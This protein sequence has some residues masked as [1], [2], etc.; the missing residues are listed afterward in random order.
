M[1]K[2][3]KQNRDYKLKSTRGPVRYG[4]RPSRQELDRLSMDWNRFQSHYGEMIHK[5]DE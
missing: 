4:R 5:G 1:Q 2:Q 3:T